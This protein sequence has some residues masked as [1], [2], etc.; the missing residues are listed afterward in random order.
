MSELSQLV[1]L[2]KDIAVASSVQSLLAWDQETYMP[3]KAIGIRTQQQGFLA[4]YVH[5]RWT[6]N[7]Y[8]ECLGSLIDLDTGELKQATLSYQEKRLVEELYRDWKKRD[9]LPVAFVE[10]QAKLVSQATHVWQEAVKKR[11]YGM[12]EPYLSQLIDCSKQGAEYIDADQDSYNVCLDNYEPNVTRDQL[13]TLLEGL[14]ESCSELLRDIREKSLSYN[15]ATGPFCIDKQWE[16]S[17]AVLKKMGFD[18]EKGRQDKS[19]HP[20]T[21]NCHP[22]DVRVTTRLRENSL[23]EALT[24]TVHEGGHG[25]YEQGLPETYFGTPLAEAVSLGIHESQSRFWE[26]HVCKS[27]AF[28]EGQFAELQGFFPDALKSVTADDLYKQVNKVEPGLIRVEADELTYVFHIYIRYTCEKALFDGEITTKELPEYWNQLYQCYLGV[29]PKHDAEGVLQ[30]IHW[31]GGHFGYFP[32]YVLGS[33]YAAQ[34]FHGYEK[35]NGNADEAIKK[36]D[37]VPFK[38]WLAKQVYAH[39]RVYNPNEL[40]ERVTGEAMS[41]GYLLGYFRSKYELLYI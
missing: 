24:S 29:E 13:D 1:A 5:H 2:C 28:W 26:N 33:I 25:L 35:E 22:S 40:M 36:G 10:K 41:S 7:D 9:V 14:V 12:F 20:F 34:L 3:A 38:T 39:G 15:K 37:W 8:K 30:D 27:K 18:F 23:F 11:E 4:A 6:S 31:S 17:L 16:Y 21:I 32:T 19:M